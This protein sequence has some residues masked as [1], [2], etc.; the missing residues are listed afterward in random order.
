MHVYRC[1]TVARFGSNCGSRKLR[2]I[3]QKAQRGRAFRR[4]M[5][6]WP[7]HTSKL[8]ADSSSRLNSLTSERMDENW[9]HVL[10]G[11]SGLAERLAVLFQSRCFHNAICSTRLPLKRSWRL[12]AFEIAQDVF[13][14]VCGLYAQRSFFAVSPFLQSSQSLRFSAALQCAR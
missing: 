2:F 7:L 4:H 10:G 6:N 9:A 11:F 14:S 3:F 5:Q 13:P 12:S 1:S 8:P